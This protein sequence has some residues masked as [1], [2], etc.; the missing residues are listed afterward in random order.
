[1]GEALSTVNTR[2]FVG[3]YHKVMRTL[4]LTLDSTSDSSEVFLGKDTIACK[5]T[6]CFQKPKS[7]GPITC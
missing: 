5:D 3:H 4:L 2:Q 6:T 7:D 1:M